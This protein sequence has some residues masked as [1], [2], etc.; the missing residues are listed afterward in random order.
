LTS[1]MVTGNR[2]L[3]MKAIANERQKTQFVILFPVA[4]VVVQ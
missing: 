2:K 4:V 3:K 1:S